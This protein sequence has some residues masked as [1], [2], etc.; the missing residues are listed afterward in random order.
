MALTLCVCT[1][2][3][4]IILLHSVQ[5]KDNYKDVMKFLVSEEA[6]EECMLRCSECIPKQPK[7]KLATYSP[8]LKVMRKVTLL[9]SLSVSTDR[10]HMIK[11]HQRWITLLMI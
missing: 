11:V 2:P 7:H 10:T 6:K 1:I 4:N 9:D 3:Q 5:T 8:G